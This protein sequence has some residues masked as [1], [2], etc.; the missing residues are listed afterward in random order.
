MGDAESRLRG[1]AVAAISD[2][3]DSFGVNGGCGELL[4]PLV[5]GLAAAGPAFTLQ[6]EPVEPG[7][8]APAADYIDEVP[9]GAVLVIA[10]GG[11]THCTVWGD[12]LTTVAQAKGIAA[13]V[14]DGCCRDARKIRE[15]R[16][17]LFS[18]GVY[19]KTGKN[20]VRLVAKQ[21]PVQVSGT[22]VNPGDFV[23]AEDSG[24]IVVPKHLMNQVAAKVEAIEAMEE[25][26]LVDVLAGMPMREARQKHRYNDYAYRAP[27]A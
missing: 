8:A 2:A 23:C 11:R 14:I 22:T 6:F 21:V 24:V 13:T 10:N 19:M 9:A 20:R 5:P 3:L 12:L 27:T 26:L 4:R 16:Y 18:K 25:R 7:E 17:P 1:A 15:L